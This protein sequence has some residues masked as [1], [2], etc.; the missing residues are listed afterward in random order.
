MTTTT[1]AAAWAA[2]AEAWEEWVAWEEWEE[3]VAWVAW[4]WT[5]KWF[6]P[7]SKYRT[8]ELNSINPGKEHN[9]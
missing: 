3:W 8:G 7:G 6:F 2:W 9:Q 4:E 1:A 5:C